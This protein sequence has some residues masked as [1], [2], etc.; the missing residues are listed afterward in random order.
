[1]HVSINLLIYTIILLPRVS[2][3][4]IS[5]TL[6]LLLLEIWLLKHLIVVEESEGLLLHEILL[7]LHHPAKLLVWHATTKLLLLLLLLLLLELVVVVLV[8]VVSAVAAHV[9]LCRTLLVENVATHLSGRAWQNILVSCLSVS[10]HCVLSCRIALVAHELFWAVA[11][12]MGRW[13]V[14]S[15]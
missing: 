11:A 4:S 7:L 2:K 8:N 6:L 3:P 5:P 12:R 1:M 15:A 13:N 10:V 9:P 14:K